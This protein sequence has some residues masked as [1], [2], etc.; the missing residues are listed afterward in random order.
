MPDRDEHL[1]KATHDEAFVDSFD[2][3]TT[4]FL[5]WVVTPLFYAAL[6]YFEA[7]LATQGKHSLDHR[8]RDSTVLRTPALRP[9]FRDFGELKNL[10][11][12]ARYSMTAFSPADIHT[13]KGRLSTI[14]T[15]VTALL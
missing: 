7:Y 2:I 11:I 8:T 5:D 6:H 15:H 1:A 12:S 14:K 10:S 13:L 4:V 9:L 3:N